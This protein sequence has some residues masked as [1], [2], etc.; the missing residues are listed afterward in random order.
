MPEASFPDAERAYAAAIR[1]KLSW[2]GPEQP[3]RGAGAERS[4]DEPVEIKLAENNAFRVDPRFKEDLKRGSSGT[5]WR[6]GP[7]VLPGHQAR[8]GPL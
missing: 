4:F 6:S 7:D 3:R 1:G 8:L 5:P 2:G